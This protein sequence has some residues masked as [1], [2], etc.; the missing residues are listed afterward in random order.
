M[1][2]YIEPRLDDREEI[3]E[4]SFESALSQAKKAGVYDKY[5]LLIEDTSVVINSLSES[6]EYP[7]VDVKYWMKETSFEDL[8]FQLLFSGRNDRSVYVRSDLLLHV[9][10]AG[11]RFERFIGTVAGTVI[12]K[13]IDIVSNSFYPWLDS[14]S[15]NKWFVPEGEV[16]PLSKLPIE[17]ANVH[18]FRRKPFED[19]LANLYSRGWIRRKSRG[20]SKNI[21]ALSGRRIVII[22]GLTCSG[23]TTAAQY[24]SEEFGYLHVEASDFMYVIYY[25]RFGFNSDVKIGSF[26]ADLLQNNPYLVVDRVIR[27]LRTNSNV[28]SHVVITGFR[29]DQEVSRVLEEYGDQLDIDLLFIDAPQDIRSHRKKVRNRDISVVSKEELEARDNREL[30]MGLS[31]I[32]KRT[33]NII[34]N[35]SS[36]D[37][38]KRL[39]LESLSLE[40]VTKKD[41]FLI[42]IPLSMLIL[43]ALYRL[44]DGNENSSAAY[45]TTEIAN[46]INEFFDENKSK[47]N[48][49][50]YFNKEIR[51]IYNVILENGKRKYSIS[52]TGLGIARIVYKEIL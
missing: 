4:S 18:D 40:K 29:L 31:M 6:K 11:P 3:L 17:V 8:D 12:D 2:N 32:R 45:T 20:I 24:M 39:L 41:S 51:P 14:Q 35:S 38:Y 52:N 5:P 47:N 15:F 16:N 19:M 10:G 34:E 36:I 26:A 42:D 37:N 50:R 33:E 23:K 9:P 44:Y 1:S 46:Y 30:D 27:F 28:S 43:L 49:S 13:E 22:N 25:E 21:D 48:V 7:G